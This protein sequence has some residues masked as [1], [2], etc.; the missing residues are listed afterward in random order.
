MFEWKSLSYHSVAISLRYFGSL[1]LPYNL[2][3]TICTSSCSKAV[4]TNCLLISMCSEGLTLSGAKRRQC[5]PR[6]RFLLPDELATVGAP[7]LYKKSLYI[8]GGLPPPTLARSPS[9]FWRGRVIADILAGKWWWPFRAWSSSHHKA[10]TDQHP[11]C[12]SNKDLSFL[13][14]I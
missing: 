14:V 12:A 5:Q 9:L 11:H 3:V 8:I 6:R 13:N 10:Y 1:S 7:S 4:W 2:L